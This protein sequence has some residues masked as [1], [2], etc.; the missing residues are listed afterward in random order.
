MPGPNPDDSLLLIRCPS[1]GQRFKVGED[2]RGR[3]VECGGCE[4]RF[5]IHDEV[6]V[7]GKK[8]YPG[9]R[10]SSGLNRFQR[11]P[12]AVAPP[13]MG[14]PGVRYEEA[15]DPSIVEPVSPQRIFA[16]L[17]G[18]ATIVMMALLII[19]G[20]KR[21]GA[22][23][24]I[25]TGNRMIMAGFAGLLGSIL[26]IYANPRARA[27]A[28]AIGLLASIV[29]VTMPIFFTGGSKSLGGGNFV[30]MQPLEIA[31]PKKTD[32]EET[33]IITELRRRIGTAPLTAE[34]ERLSREQSPRHAVGI[35]LRD[36]QERNRFLIMDYILRATGADPQSHYY[37][38]GNGDFLMVVTGIDMPLEEVAKVAEP[39]GSVK[40]VIPEIAVIEVRVNNENFVEGPI[41]KLTDRNNP[42]FY[43]LNK[44]E[45][46]SIDLERI[47]R[48]VKRLAEAEPKIYRSDITG[49]LISLLTT[50]EVKF[51]GAICDAL[52]TWSEDPAPAAEAALKVADKLLARKAPIPEEMIALIVKAK[53][54]GVIPIIDSLW[55]ETPS[56]WE[57]QY[58]EIGQ[59]AEPTLLKRFPQTKGWQ[60]QSAVRLLGKVGGANSLPY[61]EQAK[62]GADPELRV[63]LD[64]A[65][66]S[67]RSRKGS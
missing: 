13:V 12:L 37:P 55:S 32:D 15:P 51:K 63:L 62:T 33:D 22:L 64:K 6:I 38:R 44:R 35:W 17:I 16:G 14:A 4:H 45:L 60:R 10:A 3:T 57:M 49:R 41:E 54:P 28:I 2:L 31:P 47:E 18:G 67:I 39:L 30:P 5:R 27:R 11:V 29:L 42:A 52:A 40:R 26:L 23:D 56:H 20:A 66:Q 19:V 7:R 65:I 25:T 9:E 59:A 8:F 46:E 48:A 1:C 50:P 61:L 21:G 24:G 58:S 43:D 53:N 36:L 34:I